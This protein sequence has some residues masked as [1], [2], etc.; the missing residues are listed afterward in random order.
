MCLRSLATAGQI[1]GVVSVLAI[2]SL[3]H[4][5]C[6]GAFF[7]M[8]E[9]EHR[10]IKAVAS[11]TAS[12][13]VLRQENSS[14]L[15]HHGSQ[16]GKCW[17][18]AECDASHFCHPEKKTCV[19]FC[20]NNS[21]RAMRN[22][23][24]CLEGC[25]D[26]HCDGYIEERPVRL[27]TSPSCAKQVLLSRCP[28]CEA[29][30][31]KVGLPSVQDDPR[32]TDY[33]ITSY[34][35]TGSTWVRHLITNLHTA[36]TSQLR[37]PASFKAVDDFI[38]FI[39][40]G[41]G[42]TNRSMFRDRTGLRIWKSHAPFHCDSFPC[43]GHTVDRQAPTQCMCPN[44]ASKF[45]RVIYV[46]RNGYD[47]LASYFRFRMGL[48]HVRDK[49]QF[50]N[51]VNDQRM[52]PGVSWADHIRSWQHAST[53]PLQILWLRY[54]TLR[55][56]PEQELLR[57]ARFLELEATDEHI[58]FAINASSS[59]TMQQMEQKEGGL[60][61]F[62]LRYN[63]SSLKFVGSGMGD[64]ATPALWDSITEEKLA[65]WNMHNGQMQRCLGYPDGPR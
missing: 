1:I 59:E 33:W 25:R 9:P 43:K 52:Y 56:K 18:S 27:R 64:M 65:I 6:G 19:P 36:V 17:F 3:L 34:P 26:L 40:D 60:N 21:D 23:S 53:R 47:T 49:R 12:P 8:Q 45:R 31:N 37:E 7:D 62:K 55:E 28:V 57:L 41:K 48:G 20:Q 30:R 58:R 63:R 15:C 35:K 44:C 4:L 39:E 54:E 13:P 61:F 29:T 32:E 38:P 51:F 2:F 5:Q 22:C 24:S 16:Q 42:W 50:S 46:Y 11:V 14:H 10:V